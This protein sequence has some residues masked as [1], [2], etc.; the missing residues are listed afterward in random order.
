MYKVFFKEKPILLSGKPLQYPGFQ[1]FLFDSINRAEIIHKL[2]NTSLKGMVLYHHDTEHLQK[3]F[4][5]MFDI[6]P[7]AGGLVLDEQNRYLVIFR[8]GFWDI[9]K[10]KID[11]GEDAR[12]AA[13][14]EV[15]EE[16]GISK[17]NIIRNLEPTFHLFYEKEKLKLKHIVWYLMRTED[18]NKPI[19]QTEEGIEKVEFI[20]EQELIR[21]LPEMYGNLAEMINRYL[22]EKKII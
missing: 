13:T 16:C 21:R 22:T 14:R 7:A 8:N 1:T 5:G 18:R 2:L 17:I 20:T 10:G 4:F 3:E 15:Y 19:P 11:P 6:V 9:P 12:T